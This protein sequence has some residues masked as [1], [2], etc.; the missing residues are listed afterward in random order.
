[1]LV[2]YICSCLSFKN[3]NMIVTVLCLVFLFVICIRFPKGKSIADTIRSRCAEAFVRKILRFEKNNHKLQSSHVD[4]R[5]LLECKKKNVIW[6][7]L[8]FKIVNNH[9]HNYV[10]YEKCQIKLS[11]EETRAKQKRINIFEKDKKRIREE[12]QGTLSCL[13]FSY[14][15][16][17]VTNYCW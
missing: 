14:I 2:L 7:F 4:L 11:E 16:L 13:G 17:F 3:V 9:L 1:M 8:Q 5:F 15:L 10:V 6:K 12:L